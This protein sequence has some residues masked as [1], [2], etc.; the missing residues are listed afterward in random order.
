M[1]REF[2]MEIRRRPCLPKRI[3]KG[4]PSTRAMP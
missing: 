4:R 3:A 1:Q 2:Q